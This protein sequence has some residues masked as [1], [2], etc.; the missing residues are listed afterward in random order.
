M[1]LVQT[2]SVNGAHRGRTTT[3]FSFAGTD[4]HEMSRSVAR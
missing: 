4:R 3:T 1:K 2:G